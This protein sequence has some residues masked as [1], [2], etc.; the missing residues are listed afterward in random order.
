VSKALPPA[1][2]AYR[3]FSA[4]ARLIAPLA[5]AER[6]RRGKEHRE[7]LAERRGDASVGRPLG[8]LVWIHGASVGELISVLPLIERISAREV[9]VLVTSGTVTSGGLAAQRLPANVIH[10]FAP[11]DIPVYVRRFFDH[12]QPDL[13]LFVES[14][15]WPNRIIEASQRRVPMILINGVICPRPSSTCCSGS[16]FA[17]PA[18]RP[19]PSG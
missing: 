18:R 15:L 10:Q 7:R 8:P 3:L 6:A 9:N 11:L 5:L 13:A 1:L 2:R 19:T 17:S 12:W 4:A 16:T 14:D